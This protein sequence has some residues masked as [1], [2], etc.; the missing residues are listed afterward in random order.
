MARVDR[1]TGGLLPELER[2]EGKRAIVRSDNKPWHPVEEAVLIAAVAACQSKSHYELIAPRLMF[3]VG[4]APTYE[5]GKRVPI[6]AHTEN[7]IRALELRIVSKML[8]KNYMRILANNEFMGFQRS[9]VPGGIPLTWGER[10]KI[11]TPWVRKPEDLR[12]PYHGLSGILGFNPVNFVLSKYI[13]TWKSKQKESE[14]LTAVIPIFDGEIAPLQQSV[15]LL[16]DSFQRGISD[17]ANWG[18]CVSILKMLGV[19]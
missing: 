18:E 10:V 7:C 13:D 9:I 2:P 8:T 15:Q 6:R 11:I 17:R 5:K 3:A 1:R 14:I 19:V 12:I 4:H 16:K